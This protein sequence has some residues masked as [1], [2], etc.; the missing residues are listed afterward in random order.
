M[1]VIASTPSAGREP[2]AARPS[3][4]SSAQTNPLWATHTRSPVGS[5]TI[6]ASARRPASTDWTPMLAY[7]SSA[8]AVTITSPE[9]SS[10]ASR[11]AASMQAARLAFMS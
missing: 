6:A 10:A 4:S 11:L 3:V 2:W 1:R 9:S 5:V 7:S 8:T